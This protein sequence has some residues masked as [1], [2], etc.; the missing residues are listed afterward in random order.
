M[1][2][3]VSYFC[4]VTLLSHLRPLEWFSHLTHLEQTPYTQCSAGELWVTSSPWPFFSSSYPCHLLSFKSQWRS[5]LCTKHA[6][7]HRS[8]LCRPSVHRN[9]HSDCSP[10]RSQLH[11]HRFRPPGRTLLD[12]KQRQQL[13]HEIWTGW[14]L[15]YSLGTYMSPFSDKDGLV[16][17]GQMSYKFLA[18]T[19]SWRGWVGDSPVS[20]TRARPVISG[21]VYQSFL[22][23]NASIPNNTQFLDWTY[24]SQEGW[25][26][27]WGTWG[28][29]GSWVSSQR[30]HR[31]VQWGHQHR[32]LWNK[33]W[34]KHRQQGL[35]FSPKKGSQH[36]A[37]R[38]LE[39]QAKW[40]HWKCFFPL[41]PVTLWPSNLL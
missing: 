16:S 9:R 23:W 31:T 20:W 11:L 39:P 26:M 4:I 5:L 8:S 17:H 25:R 28:T 12:H 14:C 7:H 24:S 18:S 33:T 29:L 32:G 30:S 10:P 27:G 37:H 40:L 22:P 36:Q 1:I 19:S 38:H 6:H 2:I 15:W 13:G 35:G 41:W 3:S 21:E 34:E